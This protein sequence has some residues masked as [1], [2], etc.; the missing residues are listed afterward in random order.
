M[1]ESLPGGRE[2]VGFESV[3]DWS[4]LESAVVARGYDRGDV[5]HLP[6][7]DE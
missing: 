2:L 7:L 4:D 3:T 5:L 1:Y 6:E